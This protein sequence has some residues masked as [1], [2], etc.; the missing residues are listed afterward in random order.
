[1]VNLGLTA[2]HPINK[3][4]W[5]QLKS[6]QVLKQSDYP[7][8]VGTPF[9]PVRQTPQLIDLPGSPPFVVYTYSEPSSRVNWFQKEQTIAYN[10][11]SKDLSVGT[12][13]NTLAQYLF[14]EQDDSA[15]RINRF[16]K[17]Y[18]QYN[19]FSYKYTAINEGGAPNPPSGE[20]GRFETIIAVTVA[21][22]RDLLF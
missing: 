15:Q 12:K 22:T 21:Y 1:M 16:L 13:F 11:Y 19:E 3:Y 20:D 6:S 8:Q 10:L 7:S 2:A 4:F 18:P 9:V 14:G 5:E 17:D